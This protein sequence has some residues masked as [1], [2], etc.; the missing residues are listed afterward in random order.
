MRGGSCRSE[1]WQQRF[2]RDDLDVHGRAEVLDAEL[3]V[4]VLDGHAS[5]ADE[6]RADD[7]VAQLA[8]A[9]ERLAVPLD[10]AGRGQGCSKSLEREV[11]R[12]SAH[13]RAE[14]LPL[15]L[16]SQPRSRVDGPPLR[17]SFSADPPAT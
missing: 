17:E 14:P 13:L 5:R 9:A 2:E 15:E 6:M 10:C 11:Q 7:L 1:Q 3:E 8:S 12:G 16:A 4:G